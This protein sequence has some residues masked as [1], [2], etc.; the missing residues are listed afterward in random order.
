MLA[1]L[2]VCVPQEAVDS[3]K[4]SLASS[5]SP[6][7]PPEGSPAACSAQAAADALVAEALERGTKDNVTA[8]VVVF[9]RSRGGD[10]NR[11]ASPDSIP[12][13]DSSQR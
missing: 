7:T 3:V 6:S 2:C 12:R 9:G 8:I 4:F 11:P 10:P 5:A 1:C 13:L